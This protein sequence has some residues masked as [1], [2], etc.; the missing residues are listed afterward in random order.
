MKKSILLLSSA[1]SILAL[2]ACEGAKVEQKYPSSYK[3]EGLEGGI[4][5]DPDTIFGGDSIFSN[6]KDDESDDK[7]TRI[8]VNGHLWRAAL[9]TVSFMPIAS[10]DPFGGTILTEWYESK[11]TPGERHKL[12]VLILDRE[13]T[14]DGVRVSVFKQ[15][16]VGNSWRDEP[17]SEDMARQLEDSILTR[18]RQM[19]A[20]QL[21]ALP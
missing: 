20:D 14:A 7:G 19:R 17:T 21:S 3:R 15:K 13:L 10:A 12:N 4:Y 9:D 16:R 1:F 8:G 2:S 6:K 11:E 5:E 18:A